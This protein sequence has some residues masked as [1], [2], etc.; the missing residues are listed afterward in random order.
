[1]VMASGEPWRKFRKMF[2]PAFAVSN[3]E[4]LVPGIVEETMVFVDILQKSARA[5]KTI[6]LGKLM[7]VW[8]LV[9]R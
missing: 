5:E 9:R 8:L 4:T 1:M 7:P 3:L 2:N 6:Y